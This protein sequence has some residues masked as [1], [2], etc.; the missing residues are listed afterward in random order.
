M[1]RESSAAHARSSALCY[2]IM[3]IEAISLEF[4]TGCP[5]EMLYAEDLVIATDSMDELSNK[6]SV[7]MEETH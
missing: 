2:F 1:A 5:W 6:L 7:V 3:V 4:R